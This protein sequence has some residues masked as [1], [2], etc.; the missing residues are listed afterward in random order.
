MLSQRPKVLTAAM[1]GLALA[2]YIPTS[3]LARTHHPV[4]HVS[5]AATRTHHAVRTVDAP[6]FDPAVPADAMGAD[7][8][9]ADE[10]LGVAPAAPPGHPPSGLASE[11]AQWIAAADD[12]GQMPF[13]VVDKLGARVYAFDPGGEFLGSAPV[14]VGLARG[15][16]SAPG[17]GGLALKQISA[18]ERTTPA[19]RFVSRWAGS[20]GHGTMLWVD[21]NDA[22]SMHPVMSVS[23]NEHRF[24]RIKSSDP[25]EHRISYGCINVPKTFY[26]DV[27]L[28]ALSGGNAVVYV[29]P[30][31]KPIEEV[32]PAFAGSAGVRV[33]AED[34]HRS[35][36]LSSADLLADEPDRIPAPEPTRLD[37]VN[38]AWLQPPM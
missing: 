13:M 8:A 38:D 6:A 30:D 36:H 23:P 4:G 37:P 16:D 34:H 5:H 33:A 11:L 2:A 26:E 1:F 3:A 27:V 28:P 35:R 19:G 32:F 31:T 22:I 20:E 21:F 18:D 9:L 25:Q 10:A 17:I 24:T 7:D 12:N 29:M 15:D 14:L